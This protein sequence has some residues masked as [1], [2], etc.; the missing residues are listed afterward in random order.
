MGEPE[1]HET[2]PD[3]TAIG[4]VARYEIDYGNSDED[5]VKISS[6]LTY[7]YDYETG[8]LEEIL[9]DYSQLYESQKIIVRDLSKDLVEEIDVSDNEAFTSYLEEINAN[10]EREIE[11]Q[12]MQSSGTESELMAG[13]TVCWQCT[14]YD[15]SGHDRSSWCDYF[16]SVGCGSLAFK[17]NIAGFLLCAG[18]QGISCWIPAYKVCVLGKWMTT[19]PIT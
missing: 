16:F 3:T 6:Y 17:S 9:I 13:G 18:A 4:R 14:Q 5:L 11:K 1:L 19:C 15:S 12:Q 10:V 8:V 2:I 7:A